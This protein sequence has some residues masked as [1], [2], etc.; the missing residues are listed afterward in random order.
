M[1]NKS[2]V[3]N[4]VFFHLNPFLLPSRWLAVSIFKWKA[5]EIHTPPWKH[6]Y[7]VMLTNIQKF[8]FIFLRREVTFCLLSYCCSLVLWSLV[9]GNAKEQS[10]EEHGVYM[11][12]WQLIKHV[13]EARSL[14]VMMWLRMGKGREE[15]IQVCSKR[16][17]HA[18]LVCRLTGGPCRS[19]SAM[20]GRIPN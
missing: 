3:A 16:G 9:H 5:L 13:I 15:T 1:N 4:L 20:G 8:R 19:M 17:R 2:L 14:V 10:P 11:K 6:H 18:Q 7:W 12:R